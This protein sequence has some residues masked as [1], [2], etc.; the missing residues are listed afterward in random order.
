M[1][2]SGIRNKCCCNGPTCQYCDTHK[3]AREFDVTISDVVLCGGGGIWNTNDG[4][5]WQWVTPPTVDINGTFT[6]KR[7]ECLWETSVPCDGYVYNWWTQ[8]D[9]QGPVYHLYVK[10]LDLYLW[11]SR[12]D[13]WIFDAYYYIEANQW[14]GPPGLGYWPTGFLRVITGGVDVPEDVDELDCRIPPEQITNTLVCGDSEGY[15]YM[16]DGG[17]GGSAIFT[18]PNT[19]IINPRKRI[20]TECGYCHRGQSGM[21]RANSIRGK[22]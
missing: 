16:A 5:S 19:T 8:H 7:Y 15:E 6:L 13:G 10:R 18:N 14:Y 21:K 11:K 9:G 2:I 1:L 22:E 17:S 12:I 20:N 3:Q 4:Q